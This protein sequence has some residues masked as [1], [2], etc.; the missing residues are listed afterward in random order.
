MRRAFT[1]SLISIAAIAALAT[2]AVHTEKGAAAL[3]YLESRLHERYTLAERLQMHSA[4]VAARLAPAFARAGM[5]YPP[6]EVAYVA[7]KSERVLHLYA[8]GAPSDPW[9]FIRTYPVLGLS[10]DALVPLP[11]A[12]YPR[13]EE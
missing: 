3:T 7:I 6:A 5:P 10:K 11:E 12:P 13:P 2:V 9:T 1:V 8:R 4:D